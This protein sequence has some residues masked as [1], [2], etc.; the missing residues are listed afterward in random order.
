L[1]ADFL[2][3]DAA[4]PYAEDTYFE[5]ERAALAGRPHQTCGG[6]SLNDDV[7]DT[8]FTLL[9]NG[10]N[11]PRISD[12]VDRPTLLA[13]RAFPYLVPANPNPPP[14]PPPHD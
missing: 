4:K 12:G 13:S 1:L 14:P 2:V 6:R 11:G 7:M 5:I 8:I 3:V 10:G 9:V